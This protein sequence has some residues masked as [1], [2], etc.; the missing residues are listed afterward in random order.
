[1]HGPHPESRHVVPFFNQVSQ[2]L[3]F[4]EAAKMRGPLPFL[5]SLQIGM[6]FNVGSKNSFYLPLTRASL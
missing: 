5:V 1:M 2:F 6:S 3:I 4:L